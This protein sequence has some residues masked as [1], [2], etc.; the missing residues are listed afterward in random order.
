MVKKLVVIAISILVVGL[1]APATVVSAGATDATTAQTECEYPLQV[2]DD[3]GA[4]IELDEAPER[5]VTLMPSDAQTAFEIGA[6]DRVVGMPVGP[7]TDHLDVDGQED[8]TEEDGFTVDTER[9]VALEP[10]VVIAANAAEDQLIEQLR[11]LG[12]TVYQFSAAESIDD[13][14]DNVEL[15][16]QLTD[17]CEGAERTVDWM[18]DRLDLLASAVEDEEAPLTYY[19]MG[20]GFTAGADTFQDEL[21]TTAGLENL[22]AEAGIQSWDIITDEVVADLDPEWFL[23]S[24]GPDGE[25][26]IPD[27]L[28][29]TTAAQEG[30]DVVVDA[31]QF[32]Q[33]A[34]GVVFAV[35]DIVETVHPDAYDDIA[36]DLETV[37]VEY[38]SA[39]ADSDG[40]DDADA[41]EGADDSD[42]DADATE[43]ADDSDDAL[44][45]F[46]VPVAIGALVLSIALARRNQ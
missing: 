6:A 32:S 17:E 43:G 44:P 10:D 13:V 2:T 3:T 4:E 25:S 45:G 27:G 14:T 26:P 21:M 16:G 8:I 29:E 34:P 28:D 41:T 11:D 33:P 38:E 15:T 7:A 37:D 9:V 35:E 39:D 18:D 23:Y 19:E 40:D 42:D 1:L 46:G 12:L 24:E 22:A 30:N 31:N 36:E 5:V 20:G